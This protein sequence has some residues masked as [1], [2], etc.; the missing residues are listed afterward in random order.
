MGEV[1]TL[2]NKRTALYSWRFL[3]VN[4]ILV[5]CVG[6]KGVGQRS[7]EGR[8]PF[9]VG[10]SVRRLVIGIRMGSL[11]IHIGETNPAL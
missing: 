2:W 7:C 1:L 10:P 5:H 11:Q 6:G 3:G 8:L 4:K 9:G